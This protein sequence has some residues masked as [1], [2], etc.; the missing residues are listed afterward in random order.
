MSGLIKVQEKCMGEKFEPWQ[1][2][3]YRKEKYK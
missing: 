2:K 3:M 1:G